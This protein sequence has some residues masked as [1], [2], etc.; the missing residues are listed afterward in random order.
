MQPHAA[1]GVTSRSICLRTVRSA[2]WFAAIQIF[3]R[4]QDLAGLAPKGCFTPAELI[5]RVL[6]QV[7]EAQKP[8][9]ALKLRN[10]SFLGQDRMD[11]LMKAH[12]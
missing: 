12:S 6:G 11:N 4:E 8:T 5:E 10:S 1:R 3:E 7:G 9:R 2:L